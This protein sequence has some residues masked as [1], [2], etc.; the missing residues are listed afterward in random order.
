MVWAILYPCIGPRDSVFRI[1]ISSVPGMISSFSLGFRLS[2]VFLYLDELCNRTK[3]DVNRFGEIWGRGRGSEAIRRSPMVREGHSNLKE[4]LLA[5]L[6]CRAGGLHQLHQSV[7]AGM[8]CGREAGEK[9][10][11]RLGLRG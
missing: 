8:R 10:L 7:V 4:S 2:I 3:A 5:Q 9:P 6:S 1:S 11:K